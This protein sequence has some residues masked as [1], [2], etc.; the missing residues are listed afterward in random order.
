MQIEDKIDEFLAHLDRQ[1]G[2][3]QHT[4]RA[5]AADLLQFD[6]IVA[7]PVEKI[8]PADVKRFVAGLARAKYNKTTINRKLSS[9]KAFFEYAVSRGHVESNPA[10]PVRCL[11]VSKLLPKTFLAREMT[12]ILSAPDTTTPLGLRDKA[13]LELLYATGTRVSELVGLGLGDIEIGERT[14]RVRGKGG[15]ERI[16]LFGEPAREALVQYLESGRPRLASGTALK[17]KRRQVEESFEGGE[18]FLSK[19]GTRLSARS[20]GRIVAK[21]RL[22]TGCELPASPHTFRHTFATH[23]LE[24]GADLR[25]VQELLGHSNVSTT[26]VYTHVSAK[27]LKKVHKKAHP[28]G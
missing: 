3:S 4:L 17:G 19:L 15:K 14:L 21:Y 5:Y 11:K 25:S 9:I 28:R 13:I 23:M 26:Q 2:R 18:L 8:A 24:G 20:V 10:E 16:V 12:A 7:K 1:K 22:K 6:R 27:H